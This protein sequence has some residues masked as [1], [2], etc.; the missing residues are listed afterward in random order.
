MSLSPRERH[1]K[2]ATYCTIENRFAFDR[3]IRRGWLGAPCRSRNNKKW[4][5]AWISITLINF[6][7][8]ASLAMITSLYNEEI[9]WKNSKLFEKS[10]KTHD[11][12]FANTFRQEWH[13][14]TYFSTLRH[15]AISKL[16]VLAPRTF[17]FLKCHLRLRIRTL[18]R[19]GAIRCAAPLT[20]INAVDSIGGLSH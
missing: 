18:S 14:I 15:K 16:G 19:W 12:Y 2:W 9:D 1:G 7:I 10:L 20:L 13:I 3:S 4:I 17:L 8:S 6:D 11:R 5:C